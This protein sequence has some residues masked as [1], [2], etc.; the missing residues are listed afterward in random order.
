MEPTSFDIAACQ[1]CRTSLFCLMGTTRPPST[2]QFISM[3]LIYS[4][5]RDIASMRTIYFIQATIRVAR[6]SRI[7]LLGDQQELGEYSLSP[8]LEYWRLKRFGIPDLL[9][10]KTVPAITWWVWTFQG[11]RLIKQNSDMARNFTF[12]TVYRHMQ[13]Q[14]PAATTLLS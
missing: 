4:D 12:V 3:R 9:A 7:D 1:H 11:L 8:Q 14:M 6:G 13:T 10:T 2:M 5:I